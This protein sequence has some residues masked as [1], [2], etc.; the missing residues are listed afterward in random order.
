[1]MLKIFSRRIGVLAVLMVLAGGLL[2]L[3][4]ERSGGDP[5]KLVFADYGQLTAKKSRIR[6]DDPKER[7]AYR[8]L[9][10]GADRVMKGKPVSV[11]DKKRVAPSGDKHDYLTLAPYWWPDPKKK[12]GLPWIR[13]DGRVNPQTR[14][15]HVDYDAKGKLF[16][17]VNTLCMASFYSSDPKYAERAVEWLE[18]WFVNPDTR[19]NPNLNFGQ[20]VPG[21]NDGRC[22]GI[23]EWCSIDRLITPIQLLRAGGMFSPD[24]DKAITEWFEGYA[25]WLQTSKFGT[26]E[27]DTKN[28]HG[29]WYDVQLSGILLFLGREVEGRAVLERV[30]T[31]R[32]ATQIE[33]DGRQPHELARTKSMSYSKM[34]LSAFKRLVALGNKV[35]VDLG[36]YETSDGRSIRKA[37]Q[38]LAQYGEGKKKWPYQQIKKSR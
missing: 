3:G 19:M 6:R 27:R 31:K 12:D 8:S 22:F 2:P 20:G 9:I 29:T 11:V 32:I 37:E 23:I 21:R 38:F 5:V 25:E 4:A 36:N 17:S 7:K 33:P 18:V 10:A 30:K 13:H 24:T 14:G 15:E 1:M 34:N 26:Q 35:G 16:N 28:N